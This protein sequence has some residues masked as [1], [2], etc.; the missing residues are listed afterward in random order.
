MGAVLGLQGLP[1]ETAVCD[2][3]FAFSPSSVSTEV[4][5]REA[6]FS[7]V[8]PGTVLVANAPL[9]ERNPVSTN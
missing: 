9:D 7:D 4:G 8:T 3:E 5:D 2:Q 6:T 1:S